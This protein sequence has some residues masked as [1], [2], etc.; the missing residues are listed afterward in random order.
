MSSDIFSEKTKQI[1]DEIKR[2]SNVNRSEQRIGFT[3]S[4][5][6]LLH[7]G[8]LMMLK[9][10]K[11]QCDVLVVGLQTDPTIDRSEK[12]KPIQTFEE[13]KI[14]IESVKF[15]DHVIDYATENDLYQILEHL[16]PDV[17]IIG[18]DWRGKTFTGIDLESIPIHWH[19]RTH[20]FS[21]SNLRKRIFNAERLKHKK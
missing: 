16:D 12:N 19:E 10:A 20:N 15:I 13:R 17:R 1:I 7:A 8:H 6:D 18:S 9:D 2:E 3:C 4:C 14:M 21:T 5:F 11:D